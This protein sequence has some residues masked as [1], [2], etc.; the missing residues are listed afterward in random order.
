M[1]ALAPTKKIPKGVRNYSISKPDGPAAVL[2]YTVR[3]LALIRSIFW[4]VG[5]LLAV[6]QSWAYRHYTS[7]DAVAYLDM[8]DAVFPGAGLNRLVNPVWSPLYP[9]VLGLGRFIA[10]DRYN[11]IVI[12][13]FINIPIFLFA[14]AAF[15]FFLRG[16]IWHKQGDESA[17]DIAPVP[18]WVYLVVGYSAFLWSA[19]SRITLQS[20]RADMLMSGF[21]YLAIG[22]LF[23]MKGRTP[24]WSLYAALGVVLGLGYLAKAP[25]LPIGFLILLISPLMAADWRNA[26]PMAAVA[27]IL[28]LLTGSIY[29]IPL[30]R[31]QGKFTLGESAGY[32]YL[33]HIDHVGPSMYMQDVGG[34][35]GSFKH[36][37]A[38]IFDAIPTYEFSLTGS[39]T[40]PLRLDPS[41]WTQGLTHR[42][43]FKEQVKAILRNM[44]TYAGIVFSCGGLALALV[45]LYLFTWRRGEALAGIAAQW[46]LLLIG[47]AGVAM[48]SLI[49]VEH[50]YV[51]EFFVSLWLALLAGLRLPRAIINRATLGVAAGAISVLVPIA[52]RT[53]VDLKQRWNDEVRSAEAARQLEQAG[54]RAG[55]SVARIDPRA[56]FS[57]ARIAR[58]SIVTEVD[59]EHTGEFWRAAPDLQEQALQAMSKTSAKVVVGYIAGTTAPAGW[60]RLGKSR[61]WMHWL[62]EPRS[63]TASVR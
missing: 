56:D 36:P 1:I 10:R 3:A 35:A 18:P 27:A 9:F 28:L 23:R 20:L 11:E 8:S 37:P 25:M 34:A 43:H 46:P 15:E 22:L 41:Y 5:T 62:H 30:S 14:F 47:L 29:F 63:A 40:H 2:V 6:L 24:R 54:I 31:A 57:W 53:A 52:L 16:F 17:S 12:G 59:F 48:Y 32:N 51:G 44:W 50:R 38:K 60:Q 19:I 42:F 49:H 21:F 61:L 26:A 55:D 45:V 13:H 7:A 4:T 33:V 58:V 39:A